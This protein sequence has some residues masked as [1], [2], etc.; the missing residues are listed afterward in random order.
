MDVYDVIGTALAAITGLCHGK[1][2]HNELAEAVTTLVTSLRRGTFVVACTKANA[3]TVLEASSSSG[4]NVLSTPG[5]QPEQVTAQFLDPAKVEEILKPTRLALRSKSPKIAEASLQIVQTLIARGLVRGDADAPPGTANGVDDTVEDRG[6]NPSGVNS[7]GAEDASE[8]PEGVSD[9]ATVASS[10]RA[11]PSSS[12]PTE[13]ERDA[14]VRNTQACE[15]IDLICGVGVVPDE[16]VELQMLKC[17]LTAV[18][19]H[20]LRVRSKALLRVTRACVNCYLGSASEVVQT[21]AKASLTQ[22]LVVVFHRLESNGETN[23]S[24]AP[25]IRVSD[26]FSSQVRP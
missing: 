23:T 21:T 15:M 7:E 19:S 6:S 18:S 26:V 25:V 9:D 5:G 2:R 16:A 8:G 11:T 1:K 3:Q 22:M 12:F 20:S 4:A 13:T 14:L 10:P 17:L 24:V